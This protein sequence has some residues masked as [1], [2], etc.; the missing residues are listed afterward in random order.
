M[1]IKIPY[2]IGK[3]INRA[4]EVPN[5]TP[6]NIELDFKQNGTPW[7]VP[8][9]G[10]ESYNLIPLKPGYI[11]D[12]DVTDAGKYVWNN[13]PE[14]GSAQR[15]EFFTEY[16]IEGSKIMLACEGRPAGR[17]EVKLLVNATEEALSGIVSTTPMTPQEAQGSAWPTKM[18]EVRLMVDSL[19]G[20]EFPPQGGGGEGTV[21]M[22]NGVEPGVDGNVNVGSLKWSDAGGDHELRGEWIATTDDIPGATDGLVLDT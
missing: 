6:F 12:Y 14:I 16:S 13:A 10:V 7:V 21:T 20:Y 22:V 3:P 15:E 18:V 17:T 8:F 4:I 11:A 19:E 2:D 5:G 9:E 1:K